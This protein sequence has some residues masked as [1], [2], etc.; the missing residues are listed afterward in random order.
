[1][2]QLAIEPDFLWIQSGYSG[3]P[4]F[5]ETKQRVVGIIAARN[6]NQGAMAVPISTVLDRWLAGW[7]FLDIFPQEHRIL[8]SFHTQD[9]RCEQLR[10]ALI[11]LKQTA[12]VSEAWMQSSEEDLVGYNCFLLKITNEISVETLMEQ[13]QRVNQLRHYRLNTTPNIGLIHIDSSMSLPLNHRLIVGDLLQDIDHLNWEVSIDALARNILEMMER[14]SIGN[15]RTRLRDILPSNIPNR[16]L[17]TYVGEK[18]TQILNTLVEDLRNRQNK[19]IR[20][21]HSY[22]G[23]A[24]THMWTIACSDPRY[25]MRDNIRR[26][27]EYASEL[28]HLVGQRYNFVSLGVG[29][30]SKDSNIISAF[31]MREN[32]Q[33]REDF[34]YIPVD[35]SREMLREAVDAIQALPLNNRIAIQRDIEAIDGLQE[36]ALIAQGFGQQVPILYGFVGNTIANVE[37]PQSVLENIYQVMRADDLLLLEAQIFSDKKLDNDHDELIGRVEN[38]YRSPIF[39]NFAFSALLQNADLDTTPNERDICYTVTVNTVNISTESWMRPRTQILQIDC[40]FENNTDRQV[41]IRYAD[42]STEYLEVGDRIRLYRSRK[43]TQ[44]TLQDLIETCNLISLGQAQYLDPEKGVGFIL[45]ML[46]RE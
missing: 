1:M 5:D 44:T 22:W 13:I 6:Q 8:I 31:F 33:L 37:Y 20:S 32:N 18:S 25:H 41:H 39:Q 16:W 28:A 30:G 26:F 14:R 2:L 36:I 15:P 19:R 17:L 11:S 4:V 21:V 9:K 38:E 40:Y 34:L 29:E 46:R 45:M 7:R 10:D 24:P 12:I 35:M 42:E 43:F 27:P 23:V 3:S